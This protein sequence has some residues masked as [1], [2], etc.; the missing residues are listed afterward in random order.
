[1][2][3]LCGDGA[4]K[5]WG[6]TATTRKKEWLW[7]VVVYPITSRVSPVGLRKHDRFE[8]H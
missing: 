7:I 8:F 1:M 3:A 5:G 4:E 6:G 2:A